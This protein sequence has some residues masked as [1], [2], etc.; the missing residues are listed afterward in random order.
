[1]TAECYWTLGSMYEVT[2]E[3]LF[4]RTSLLT[5]PIFHL[6]LYMYIRCSDTSLASN[7]LRHQ[8]GVLQEKYERKCY[9]T[10]PPS[11]SCLSEAET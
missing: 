4:H 7:L 8:H 6:L 9:S 11:Y 2:L 10:P 1:M 3:P 5:Y